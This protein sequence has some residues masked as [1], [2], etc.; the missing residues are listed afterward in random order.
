[1]FI[2]GVYEK[3]WILLLSSWDRISILKVL[4]CTQE[5]GGNRNGERII[6]GN[7]Q[8]TNLR[9]QPTSCNLDEASSFKKSKNDND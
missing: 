4:I 7:Y 8:I 5:V 6:M 9:Y 3:N 2:W 1:M